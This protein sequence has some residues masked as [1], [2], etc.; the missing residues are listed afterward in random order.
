M[1]ILSVDNFADYCLIP[2]CVSVMVYVNE[3]IGAIHFVLAVTQALYQF[4]LR[5]LY[6]NE[7]DGLFQ[8]L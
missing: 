6:S 7:S 4:N 2:D 3:V 5:R 8:I 1:F